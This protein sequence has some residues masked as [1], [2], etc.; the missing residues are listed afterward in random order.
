MSR[1]LQSFFESTWGNTAVPFEVIFADG[2][3]YR[4]KG[5]LPEVI[6]CFKSRLAQLNTIINHGWG[7]IES[8][9]HQSVD[10][11]GDL[12][13][14]IRASAETG[15]SLIENTYAPNSVQKTNPMPPSR[16]ASGRTSTST[17]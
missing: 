15:P 6:I 17:R 13:L 2:A 11:K 12:K 14:L 16:C 4:N 9:I 1:L 3:R 5:T 8:Y 10:I 7:L